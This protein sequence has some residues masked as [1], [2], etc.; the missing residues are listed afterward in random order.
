MTKASREGSRAARFRPNDIPGKKRLQGKDRRPRAACAALVLATSRRGEAAH[1]R[2]QW[3]V[4]REP[5]AGRR[6]LRDA[7]PRHGWPA[8]ARPA[9]DAASPV[10]RATGPG[11]EVTSRSPGSE[12]CGRGSPPARPGRLLRAATVTQHRARTPR[13]LRS[14]GPRFS[15]AAAKE[16]AAKGSDF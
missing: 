3:R 15:T 5:L 8:H 9:G 12:R 14:E 13:R 16:H 1:A 7:N 10:L 4:P 6:K 11:G 2:Q